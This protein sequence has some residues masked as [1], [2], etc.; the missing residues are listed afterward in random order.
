MMILNIQIQNP[1][2]LKHIQMY[3]FMTKNQI[4]LVV[5]AVVALF[6]LFIF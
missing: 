2:L 6:I 4:I 5:F 3:K 1:K